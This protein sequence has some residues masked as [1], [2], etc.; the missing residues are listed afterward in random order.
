MDLRSHT[1]GTANPTAVNAD[2]AKGRKRWIRI[3]Y[4]S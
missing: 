1:E 3:F 2:V 4:S